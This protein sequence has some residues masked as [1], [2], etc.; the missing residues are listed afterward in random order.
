[1]KIDLVKHFDNYSAYL[2]NKVNAEIETKVA[3]E[4][5]R[6][7]EGILSLERK[8]NTNKYGYATDSKS[9]VS[10]REVIDVIEGRK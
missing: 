7:L 2:E 1:M 6:I 5:K 8:D 3:N 9:L 10:L 4:N